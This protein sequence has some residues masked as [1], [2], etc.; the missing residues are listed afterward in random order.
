MSID[1][2]AYVKALEGAGVDRT[3]AEAHLKAMTDAVIPA[4][5]T[6]ADL[7]ALEQRMDARFDRQ[8]SKID[9]LANRLDS[10]IDL[11]ADRQDSKISLLET[12]MERN[13]EAMRALVMQSTL[14]MLLGT[15]A[16]GGLLVRFVK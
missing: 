7:R 3:L 6:K 1:T 14:A 12:K 10:K 4:L 16:I 5:A 13:F 9:Q 8:D 15:L 2:L 11:I